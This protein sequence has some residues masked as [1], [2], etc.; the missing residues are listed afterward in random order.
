MFGYP[1]YFEP[2]SRRKAAT[3]EPP[4]NTVDDCLREI[5]RCS[6][7]MARTQDEYEQW[8]AANPEGNW[9]GAAS[10]IDYWKKRKDKAEGRFADLTNFASR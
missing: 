1:C 10:F 3:D 2:M 4:L 9:P 7:E 6:S 5:T 8:S